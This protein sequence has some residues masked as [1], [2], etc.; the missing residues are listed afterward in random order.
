MFTEINPTPDRGHGR[1]DTDPPPRA[2]KQEHI[3]DLRRFRSAT[4]DPILSGIATEKPPAISVMAG[5]KLV[6][7]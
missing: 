3:G 6:N 1:H 2:G 4:Y 5:S 7:K